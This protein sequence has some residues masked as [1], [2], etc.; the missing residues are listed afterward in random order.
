MKREESANIIK[1]NAH[2]KHHPVRFRK[3]KESKS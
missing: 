2:E 3:P 1:V